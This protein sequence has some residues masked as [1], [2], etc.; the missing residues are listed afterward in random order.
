MN[1]TLD[2]FMAGPNGELD[3]HFP[4]WNGEMITYSCEQLSM[5]DTILLGRITYQGMADYWSTCD[6]GYAGNRLDRAFAGMMNDYTKIVFSKSLRAVEWNN[7]RLVKKNIVK[8][9][10]QLK[11]QPGMDLIIYGSGSIASMLMQ[12]GLVDECVLWVHP[13]V[14]R[15]G[16][17]FFTSMPGTVKLSLVNTK[18]FSSGVVILYYKMMNEAVIKNKKIEQWKSIL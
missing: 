5:M 3:W 8:E 16:K 1:I 18:K 10:K 7:T 9:I 12:F 2:G 15:D 14:L 13:V 11:R 6:A 4:Y 17:S